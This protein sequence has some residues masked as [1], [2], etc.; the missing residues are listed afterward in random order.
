MV[1]K[2]ESINFSFIVEPF[3][4]SHSICKC[5]RRWFMVF[6]ILPQNMLMAVF[7]FS[8]SFVMALV[9]YCLK[10]HLKPRLKCILLWPFYAFYNIETIFLGD[11]LFDLTFC[12][13][14]T[15]LFLHSFFLDSKP[16]KCLC[17]AFEHR[18]QYYMTMCCK[19]YWYLCEPKRWKSTYTVVGRFVQQ[20]KNINIT[21]IYF[22]LFVFCFSFFSFPVVLV[23]M[24]WH[25]E[26]LEL[27]LINWQ[28]ALA[29]N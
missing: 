29:S 16:Q 7:D 27:S 13:G 14:H 22:H 28:Q 25:L 8:I 23:L 20:H 5:P 6:W 10:Y 1:V 21:P 17:S 26:C 12:G 4:N 2:L 19:F 3:K 9:S 15:W 18:K 24:I 11:Y